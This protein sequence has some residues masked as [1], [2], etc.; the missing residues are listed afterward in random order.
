MC[1][2]WLAS[3]CFGL[4]PGSSSFFWF[5]FGGRP[6]TDAASAAAASL[7][8][9]AVLQEGGRCVTPSRADVSGL[10]QGHDL[11]FSFLFFPRWVIMRPAVGDD[12]R[13]EMRY[14]NCVSFL[15][16]V[17]FWCCFSWTGLGLHLAQLQVFFFSLAPVCSL[18]SASNSLYTLGSVGHA[19]SEA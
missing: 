17:L 11:F 8:Q 7:L 2:A 1:L 15:A 9:R 3:L 6:R 4:G 16:L 14:L 5:R 12:E 10:N 19:W 18:L 13:G